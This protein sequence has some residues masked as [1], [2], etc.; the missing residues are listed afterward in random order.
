MLQLFSPCSDHLV[1]VLL[2]LLLFFLAG[3][4]GGPALSCFSVL[5][6]ALR[7]FLVHFFFNETFEC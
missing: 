6:L 5:T 2:L 3:C 1:T 4:G 7:S